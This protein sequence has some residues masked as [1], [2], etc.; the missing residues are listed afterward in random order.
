M[1]Y[2][3]PHAAQE[4]EEHADEALHK[5]ESNGGR[6]TTGGSK[7]PRDFVK[8][9]SGSLESIPVVA[10]GPISDAFPPVLRIVL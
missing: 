2:K 9:F 1:R 10:T 4:M 6:G 5:G 7:Q 3:L 8:G